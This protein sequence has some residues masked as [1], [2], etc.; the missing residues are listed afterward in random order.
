M[1]EVGLVAFA[2]CALQIAETLIPKYRGEFSKHP[3]TQPQLLAI[4]C[5]MR[6]ADWTFREAKFG[7]VNTSTCA[8]P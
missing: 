5:L 8:R 3:Y 4:H 7:S 1:A 6:Y 2:H